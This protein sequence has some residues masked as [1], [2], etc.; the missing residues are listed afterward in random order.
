MKLLYKILNDEKSNLEIA[1]NNVDA[2][3]STLALSVEVNETAEAKVVSIA[4][5]E[6]AMAI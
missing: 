5:R 4:P 1:E 6:L 3:L 2:L